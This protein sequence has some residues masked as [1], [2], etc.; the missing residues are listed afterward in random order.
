M[1]PRTKK[2]SKSKA[3]DTSYL[4]NPNLKPRDQATEF[5]KD[6]FKEFV[7]C[8]TDPVYFINKYVKIINVD[9][10]LV[11]FSLYP[12]QE[13]LINT[14]NDNR[15]SIVL[16][17]RQS[18]KTIC[19]VS[20]ILWASLFNANYTIAMLANKD[21]TAKELL[22]RYQIAYENLP[23]WM[24]Q[25]VLVWN[26]GDIELENG[27]RVISAATSSSAIRGKSINILALD[28]LAHVEPNT[29]VDFFQSV[30]PTISSGKSTK[31]LITSTPKGM[32]LFYNLWVGAAEKRNGYTPIEVHWTDVPG[33]DDEWKQKEIA[34]LGSEEAFNQEYG[35]AFL[36]SSN[37]LISGNKLRKLTYTQ[38]VQKIGECQIFETPKHNR[39]YAMTV[40]SAH[41][42]G[43][44]YSAFAVVDV[45]E[46]PYKVV[47][48]FY[49]NDVPV[50]LFP[51]HIFNAAK[52][53]NNAIMLIEVNDLGQQIANIIKNDFEYDNILY[54]SMKSQKGQ[55]L[56]MG[57]GN[58][59]PGVK[60][61]KTVK[62]TGCAILKTLIEEDKL[63]L[64]DFNILY[65]L[66]SFVSKSDSYEADIGKHDDLVMTLVIFAWMTMQPFYRELVNSDIR[67]KIFKQKIHE[68]DAEMDTFYINSND[69]LDKKTYWKEVESGAWSIF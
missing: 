20:Y 12:F 32:E 57:Y 23:K 54:C 37:T 35:N 39:V 60:M 25:G 15:F 1:M 46:T 24:Q 26:K 51:T 31:I 49:K 62:K 9:H 55:Q 16:S 63:I 21:S 27:T 42:T 38:P 4:G 47:A 67:E 58:S 61:T 18:G 52:L 34:N 40:D 56:G 6:Q 59:M 17:P 50:L 41:G 14:F 30:Y 10:G 65:E 13:K 53:Y 69:Y 64:N 48:T 45:T 3:P 66:Y 7:R 8:S 5:T 11:P 19:V 43:L 28:E 22:H 29:Q 44:D 2:P 68:L 33:R 36:G